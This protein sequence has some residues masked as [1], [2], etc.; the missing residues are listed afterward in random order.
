MR[1][2]EDP[3]PVGLVGCGRWGHHVLRD[4]R[5]L[6]C[7]VHVAVRS[8]ASVARAREGGAASIVPALEDLPEVAGIVITTPTSTHAELAERAL[9]RDVP[10]YVE[11]PL[12][13]DVRAAERL[14]TIG[15]G[16][17]FVMDKWRYHPAVVELARM[18]RAEELGPVRAIH[19]RRVTDAHRYGDDQD[20]V[21]CHAPHDLSIVLEV[22]GALPPAHAAVEEWM[23]GER[24]SMV[25]M[26]GG[27][28]WVT[29][30]V[31][32]VAPAH[33]R[34]L[35][36]VFEEGAATLDGGWSE[37]L[38]IVRSPHQG[39]EVE[40]RPTPGELPLL[41]EL[42]AFIA[43]ARGGLAPR[44]SVAD[45]VAIVRCIAELGALARTAAAAAS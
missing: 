7:V 17:L 19:S 2:A 11:K 3:T 4:L 44:S 40:V 32:C 24:V 25:A 18:A 36:V 8:E 31:S 9:G 27:P 22:L 43:H 30:E 15:D 39:H 13:A 26:L 21:W 23:A 5:A 42:R 10:V 16:R 20:T 14:L 28:P 1:E 34:E 29:L 35:R 37:E 41:A 6:G 33:R 45:G 12:S 38:R